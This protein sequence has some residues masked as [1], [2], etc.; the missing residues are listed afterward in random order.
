MSPMMAGSKDEPP[1]SVVAAE[2]KLDA[3]VYKPSE[4]DVVSA[5]PRRG[6]FIQLYML[7]ISTLFLLFLT[8]LVVQLL[9]KTVIGKIL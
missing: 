3:I 8:H 9:G 1:A 6:K 5:I 2:I 4:H 7:Q